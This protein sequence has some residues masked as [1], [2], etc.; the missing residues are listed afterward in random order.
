M[1]LSKEEKAQL[2]T[3]FGL[4]TTDTGSS[5]VQVALL[6]KRI[7]TLNEHLKISKKDKHS[8]RGLLLMVGRRRRFLDYIAK[9]NFG[10]YQDLIKRLGLRK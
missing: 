9:H 6:T 10:Q 4:S 3:E 2:I 1:A 8:R 7:N 5:I